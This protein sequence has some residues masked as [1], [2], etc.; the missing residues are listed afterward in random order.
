[1]AQRKAR[2]INAS[3]KSSVIEGGQQDGFGASGGGLL[4][5]ILSP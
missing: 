3:K 5:E 2:H 1:M 4:A